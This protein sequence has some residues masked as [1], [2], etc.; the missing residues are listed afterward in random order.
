[1]LREANKAFDYNNR[2]FSL[3]RVPTSQT[4]VLVSTL[5]NP[6]EDVVD[7]K[8][9][10]VGIPGVEDRSYILAT[11]LPVVLTICLAYFMGGF[12]GSKDYLRLEV[13]EQWVTELFY[14]I[15]S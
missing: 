10:I 4:N 15:P 13:F 14:T 9:P 5:S 6:I 8:T 12:K 7:S 3:I 11:M 2:I 1:L